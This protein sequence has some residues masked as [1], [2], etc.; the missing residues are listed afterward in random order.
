[1][2][3]P[4]PH[5]VAAIFSMLSTT[6]LQDLADDIATHGLLH[7]VVL[8]DQGRVLDGR[9]RL[10]ACEIANVEPSFTTYR[11]DDP[12]GFVISENVKRRHLSPSRLAMLSLDAEAMYAE[13]ARERMLAGV[14]ADPMALVPQGLARDQAAAA[15]GVSGRLVGQAKRVSEYPE[16]AERVRVGDLK[17]KRAERIL[18]DRESE[19]KRLEQAR[20]EAMI[21]EQPSVDI[22][23]GDFREVLADLEG[24]DA[25]ITDPPYGREYL[26]LLDDLAAW[27]DK[28]LAPD[29]VMLVM[30]GLY[31]LEEAMAGSPVTGTI[32]GPW[33]TS[34]RARDI[35]RTGHRCSR[36][37]SRSWSTAKVPALTT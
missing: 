7:P 15:F 29:G 9:N 5:P 13:Q 17:L 25:I 33:P 4:A 18:R 31:H 30:F 1:M 3:A 12:L 20:A 21:T 23:L 8:D 26:P 6:G 19:A 24:I 14:K 34:R 37:G 32:A 36:I 28:V 22:R 35:R 16:L 11:G 10:A 27:A 2:T